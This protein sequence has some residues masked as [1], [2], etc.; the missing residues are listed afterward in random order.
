MKLHQILYRAF[1][2]GLDKV[3]TIYNE[4]DQIV[5]RNVYIKLQGEGKNTDVLLCYAETGEPAKDYNIV[6]GMLEARYFYARRVPGLKIH[7]HDNA[8]EDSN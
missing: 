6:L 8:S 3:Y 7:V 2:L 5:L 4:C 1:E